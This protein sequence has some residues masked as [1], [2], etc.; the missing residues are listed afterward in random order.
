VSDRAEFEDFLYREAELLD[1]R[2]HEAW[3]GL[4]APDGRYWVPLD[5]AQPDGLGHA[6][7][8]AEDLALLRMRVGHMSHPL[9]H[10]HETPPRTSRL[11]GNLRVLER[12]DGAATLAA[13]FHLLE[14]HAERHRAFAGRLT[15]RLVRH[16]G[17]WRIALKRVDLVDVDAA[18]ESIQIIF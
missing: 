3:L 4:F 6:S 13:R 2:D 1:A 11:V 9:A 10:G 18:H 15:H 16:D 5:P 14:W 12:T 7:I 17:A 8:F